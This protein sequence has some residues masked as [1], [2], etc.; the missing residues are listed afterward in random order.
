MYTKKEERESMK[1]KAIRKELEVILPRYKCLFYLCVILEAIALSLSAAYVTASVY[2]VSLLNKRLQIG[3]LQITL[4]QEFIGYVL[5]CVSVFMAFISSS[6]VR[7]KKKAIEN[8]LSA[9]GIVSHGTLIKYYEQV[10]SLVNPIDFYRAN[11]QLGLKIKPHDEREILRQKIIW[12]GLPALIV[13]GVLMLLFCE[14]IPLVIGWE[15]LFSYILVMVEYISYKFIMKNK[16]VHLFSENH[17]QV[18][19]KKENPVDDCNCLKHILKMKKDRYQSY[20]LILNIT[21]NFTNI[22]AIFITII[23]SGAKDDLRKWLCLPYQN[24]NDL[25]SLIFAVSAIIIYILSVIWGDNL[26]LQISNL[27][28]F[29]NEKMHYSRAYYN[30]MLNLYDKRGLECRTLFSNKALEIARGK[31]EHN[32][33][34]LNENITLNKN[35]I[36]IGVKNMFT[37]EHR[38]INNIPRIK[39]TVAVF[40]IWAFCIFSWNKLELFN[41]IYIIPCTIMFALTLF[42]RVKRYVFYIDRNW[43]AFEK[44]V[45]PTTGKYRI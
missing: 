33:E 15:I 32:V 26:E 45:W 35:L 36:T 5:F 42:W 22:S 44:S 7:K 21:M 34:I 23:N 18:I 2:G 9:A 19:V 4:N 6:K 13:I 16:H 24:A 39:F 29:E 12:I 40:L 41:L 3:N 28:I 10:K 37:V 27:T 1:T 43:L 31:H 20:L 38:F 11:K 8:C 14:S 25:L 30:D 17:R